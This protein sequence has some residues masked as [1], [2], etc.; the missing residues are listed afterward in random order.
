LD[1]ITLPNPDELIK[2]HPSLVSQIGVVTSV[3]ALGNNIFHGVISIE[4]KAGDFAGI[5]FP[6]GSVFVEYQTITSSSSL[7]FPRYDTGQQL[8]RQ[9]PDFRTLLYWDP[10]IELSSQ[11]IPLNF[12]SSDRCAFYDI[13]VKGYTRSG[14]Y[15]FG[16]TTLE[17]VK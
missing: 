4:T 9:I 16:K 7:A 5:N 12:Y 15:C 6:A 1:H 14:K 8:N 17:V 2:I 11:N 3:Y 13:I 10:E